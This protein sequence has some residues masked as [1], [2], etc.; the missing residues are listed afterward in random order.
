MNMGYSKCL[1]SKLIEI[2]D[3]QKLFHTVQISDTFVKCLKSGHLMGLKTEHTKV[4][5]S[6]KLGFQTS[7]D[8]RHPNCRRYCSLNVAAM[9]NALTQKHTKFIYIQ[10][11]ILPIDFYV[12]YFGLSSY[13]SNLVD[14]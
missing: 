1:K 11:F 6:D 3:T 9:V 7:S 10:I 13:F 12:P 5:I 8:F 4:W 2:S 14:S